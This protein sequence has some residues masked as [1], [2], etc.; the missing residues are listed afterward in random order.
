MNPI[1]QPINP[2]FSHIHTQ[3]SESWGWG[4][5]QNQKTQICA[6][7]FK[8]KEPKYV[9]YVSKSENPNM[10]YMFQNQ[11]TQICAIWFK[12][13]EAK[14]SKSKSIILSESLINSEKETQI[15]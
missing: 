7:C 2:L 14:C 3:T 4:A 6:L 8:I 11:R 15:L 13:R 5:D 10:C 1:L 12:I 9:L